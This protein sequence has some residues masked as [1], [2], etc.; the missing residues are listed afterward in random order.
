MT[1]NMVSHQ[2]GVTP[3]LSESQTSPLP[4]PPPSPPRAHSYF[5]AEH[6][7][8]SDAYPSRMNSPHLSLTPDYSLGP[9]VISYGVRTYVYICIFCFV[10]L[11]ILPL[12][13]DEPALVAS[14]YRPTS[15]SLEHYMPGI[16]INDLRTGY[17]TPHRANFR[18]IF[19]ALLTS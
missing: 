13:R 16:L 1:E 15:S 4:T 2:K 11:S 17:A 3:F 14:R 5:S 7:F 12:P 9:T 8:I 10:S 6:G 19:S 18:Y